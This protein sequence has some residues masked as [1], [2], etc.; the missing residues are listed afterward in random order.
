MNT[1]ATCIGCGCDD[2]HACCSEATGQPCSWLMVDRN[3]GLGVC[4]ECPDDVERWNAGDRATAVPVVRNES[5][6]DHWWLGYVAETGFRHVE[7]FKS[8]DAA[9]RAR[10]SKVALWEEPARITAP[11]QAASQADAMRQIDRH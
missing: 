9:Q 10:R 8:R 11:F 1:T 3:A 5:N 4:S 2:W 7:P 6:G